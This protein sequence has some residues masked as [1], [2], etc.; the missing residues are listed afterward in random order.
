[1]LL[2]IYSTDFPGGTSS[3]EH[4]CQCR[5]YRRSGFHPWVRKILWRK[6][7]QPTPV[8]S[9]ETPMDRGAWQ[10]TVHRVT[11]SR[12]GLKRLCMHTHTWST[13][14]NL[15]KL[16]PLSKP[17]SPFIYIKKNVDFSLVSKPFLLIACGFG[18]QQNPVLQPSASKC[19][20]P[21]MFPASCL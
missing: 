7:W 3:K 4:N 10:A 2:N 9:P 8:F 12:T 14:M 21:S 16:L 1:M 6:A 18:T 15:G 20:D 19:K 5:R 17:V 13:S 11:N